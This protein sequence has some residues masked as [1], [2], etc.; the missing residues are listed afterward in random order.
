MKIAFFT[1]WPPNY[2]GIAEYVFGIVEGLSHFHEILVVHEKDSDEGIVTLPNVTFSSWKDPNIKMSLKNINLFVFQF[3]N[4]FECHGFI[5]N[6]LN[7]SVPKILHLHDLALCHFYGELAHN[8]QPPYNFKEILFPRYGRNSLVEYDFISKTTDP[9]LTG[10]SVKYP[11]LHDL[12]KHS[13]SII[14][15]SIFAKNKIRE[16]LYLKD[17]FKITQL[18][19][20]TSGRDLDPQHYVRIPR[21]FGVFGH[22][23][24]QKKVHLIIR[25][26]SKLLKE[27]LDVELHIYGKLNKQYAES[28]AE[29]FAGSEFLNR[30]IYIHGFTSSK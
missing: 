14:V 6:F 28:C 8:S 4:N 30:G 18:Y 11:L 7:Y 25:L 12:L 5:L 9:L 13:D 10:F 16:H 19:N 26:F 20:L 23:D 22:V 2:S 17:V 29:E 21:K 15:H 1:P 24:P 3:G 27:G